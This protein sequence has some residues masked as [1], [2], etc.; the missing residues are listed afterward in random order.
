MSGYRTMETGAARATGVRERADRIVALTETDVL[1]DQLGENADDV[2]GDLRALRKPRMFI[3]SGPSGVGKDTVI[4][5]MRIRYPEAY[6]AVTATTRQRRPGEIDGVHYYF[7]DMEAF[8]SRLADGE[9]LESALVYGHRY[10]VPRGPIR[11]ALGRGQDVFVKVD[12]QG[13]DSIRSLVP[14]AISVFLAPESMASLLQRLRAR[15]TDDPEALMKRFGTA[16]RELASASDFDYVIFNESDRVE[17]AVELIA[18]IVSAERARTVQ[19][20]ISL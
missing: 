8:E 15:K 20:D 2:I 18:A 14:R 19:H 3:I 11:A 16:S 12:I 6:F 1:T 17:Q 10:G 5:A 13:A 9:F 4:E 7:M